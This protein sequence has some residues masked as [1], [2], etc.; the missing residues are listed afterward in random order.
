[1]DAP[2]A[3]HLRR[4]HPM[5]WVV[6]ND[7][8]TWSAVGAHR[9]HRL[10]RGV[11]PGPDDSADAAVLGPRRSNPAR[12]TVCRIAKVENSHHITPLT[13]Y[14]AHILVLRM[15]GHRTP[16]NT[17]GLRPVQRVAAD[18]LPTWCLRSEALPPACPS[19]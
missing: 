16:A 9:L 14:K 2:E 5:D 8:D 3:E 1:V 11:V 17:A 10:D 12:A 15:T 6:V 4:Q 7:Q 13:R 18:G 19:V